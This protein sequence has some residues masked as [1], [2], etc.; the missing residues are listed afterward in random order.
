MGKITES[1]SVDYFEIKVNNIYGWPKKAHEKMLNIINYHRSANQNY[2]EVPPYTSQN[3]HHQK[4][5]K[6]INGG[7]GVKKSESSYTASGNVNW[8]NHYQKQYGD[9]LK[10]QKNYHLIQQ[11]HTW[12]S[13]HR[14]S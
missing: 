4:S 9:S 3:G 7:E 2:Y 1:T 10:N 11:F 13:I 12:A 8:Y 5:V 14:K 6:T